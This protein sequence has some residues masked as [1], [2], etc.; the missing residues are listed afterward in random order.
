MLS[1]IFRYPFHLIRPFYER[2]AF[3]RNVIE[4]IEDSNLRNAYG[5]CRAI[6]KH[7]AGTFYMAIRFLP[8]EKQRHIFAM[9]SLCRS[10][11]NL[12]D[13]KANYG[14]GK[15]NEVAIQNGMSKWKKDLTLVYNNRYDG[16]D[17]ILLAFA[18]M[19]R[20]R[21]ISKG[22]PF[23]LIEGITSDLFKNR[24]ENFAKLYEYSYKVASVVGLMITEV[25]GYTQKAA[26]KHAVE[27]GIAMQLTN[28]LR[29]VGE[30][31]NRNR[32]YLPEDEMNSYG[33]SE[34]DLFAHR[35]T[36]NFIQLMQLQIRRA[37]EYY[38]HAEPGIFMLETDSRLPVYMAHQN[39]GAILDRIEEN[40][41]Q[42]F[43]R[44]AYLTQGEKLTKLPKLWWLSRQ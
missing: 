7:Y 20:V 29:D 34:E 17:P 16:S 13:E 21:N 42:V 1:D 37:R 43:T 28:I 14:E 23:M 27:L 11:D 36:G 10:L 40:G 44:R 15:L 6:T 8:N 22:L 32:I 24:Y 33:V 39:Y 35:L 4:E 30:D 12:V 41:Y 19:L 25:F 18:D 3:H 26:L 31:L 38:R 9:Y 2:T 5:V